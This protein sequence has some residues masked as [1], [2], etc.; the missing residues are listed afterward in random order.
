[1]EFVALCL[2]DQEVFQSQEQWEQLLA[3]VPSD[4]A[5]DVLILTLTGRAICTLEEG[6]AVRP[7]PH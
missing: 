2:Q 7:G 5:S 6:M 3:L 1:M 4:G